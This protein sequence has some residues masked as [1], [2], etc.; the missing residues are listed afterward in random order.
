MPQRQEKYSRLF[1]SSL[2]LT[3]PGI[4]VLFLLVILHLIVWQAALA[5]GVIILLGTGYILSSHYSHVEKLKEYITALRQLKGKDPLPGIPSAAGSFLY[6]EL[7]LSLSRMAQERQQYR[8][9]LEAVTE[10]NEAILSSLPDPLIML[11]KKRQI[12]RGNP[13]AQAIFGD[14]ITGRELST[15]LR[16][17]GILSAVDSVENS[18]EN[19]SRFVEFKIHGRVERYMLARIARMNE[20]TWDGTRVIVSLH[21]QTAAKKVDQMRGDFIANAS[22]ELKTPLASLMGFIET[23]KGPAKD[24][25]EA[26]QRFLNIMQDQSERMSH[27][28]SDLLSLSR[29]ELLEH[30]PP[31]GITDLNN[32]ITKITE[33]L[34]TQIENKQITIRKDLSPD[35][36]NSIP[37]LGDAE[38]LTQLFQNL[39]ENAVKY[40]HKG[41]TVTIRGKAY[42]PGSQGMRRLGRPSVAI[43]IIDQGDGIPRE[44]IPRLT[45]RFYRVDAARSRELGG[46]GLGLA[47][48]KH[49]VNRHRGVLTIDSEVGRGST[50]TVYL[51]KAAMSE[52]NLPAWESSNLA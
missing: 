37:V 6:P 19:I 51:P 23:L 20:Q 36:E 27:L 2:I 49:I 5:A 47:I 3:S 22:H 31:T 30:T 17:P 40:G 39:L 10:G 24:D 25:P 38:A 48:V 13:A 14:N 18:S 29:I 46:T 21:D 7:N 44:H 42:G 12:I 11:G 35:L 15:I 1:T 9:Q 32:I 34:H 45:E 26:Q 4:A 8:R 43:A 33:G 41:T 52:M 16:N 28:V 50:F